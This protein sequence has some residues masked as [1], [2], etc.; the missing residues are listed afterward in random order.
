MKSVYIIHFFLTSICLLILP[1]TINAQDDYYGGDQN[2]VPTCMTI[3]DDGSYL[4]A[5]YSKS[6]DDGSDQVFILKLNTNGEGS[7][8]TK[9]WGYLWGPTL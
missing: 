1:L 6:Y 7:L 3:S 4:L 5:G 2:D 8:E 9:L